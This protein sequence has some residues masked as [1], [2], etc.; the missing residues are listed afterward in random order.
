MDDW[1]LR[2]HPEPA[3]QNPILGRRGGW[4]ALKGDSHCVWR[5]VLFHSEGRPSVSPGA[6]NKLHWATAVFAYFKPCSVFPSVFT[7]H[8]SSGTRRQALLT[9]GIG[10]HGACVW[11]RACAVKKQWLCQLKTQREHATCVLID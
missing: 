6:P 10:A 2:L 3:E 7:G 8:L 4:L 1:L 9:D 5:A 11:F